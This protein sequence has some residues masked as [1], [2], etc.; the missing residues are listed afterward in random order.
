MI[1]S[2]Y[3]AFRTTF[4]DVGATTA[5]DGFL[6]WPGESLLRTGGFT[7]TLSIRTGGVWVPFNGVAFPTASTF[8]DL[9]F[10][11]SAN[12]GASD[13]VYGTD[14]YDWYVSQRTDVA[15]NQYLTISRN[16]APA[17]SI[18]RSGSIMIDYDP[19]NVARLLPDHAG[20]T[21]TDAELTL[22]LS[23]V[24]VYVRRRSDGAFQWT[25]LYDT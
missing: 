6:E 13:S 2:N 16:D 7:G 10:R 17:S 19:T 22:L 9:P 23:R 1:V 8:P 20:A 25:K 4:A 12:D 14:E 18:S 3:A 24:H 11:L 5:H 21:F 15:A